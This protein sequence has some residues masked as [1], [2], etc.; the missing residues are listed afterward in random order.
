ML[1][2]SVGLKSEKGCA[3]DAWQKLKSTGPTSRQRGLSTS[4]NPKQ[5]KKE[6][7]NGKNLSRVPGGCLIPRWTDRQIVG[8]K[9][10]LTL[11]LRTAGRYPSNETAAPTIQDSLHR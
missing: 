6:I 7:E 1:M 2:S 4:I 9:I 5:S 8:C 10:T 3:G 11:T